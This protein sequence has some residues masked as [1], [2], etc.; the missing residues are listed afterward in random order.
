MSAALAIEHG[1]DAPVDPESAERARL[2]AF[3]RDVRALEDELRA[4]MG[5]DDVAH[6]ERLCA[7][8]DKGLRWGR[9]LTAVGFD[10]ITFGLG[11]ALLSVS[12]LL[13]V[14]PLGHDIYHGAWDKVPGAERFASETWDWDAPIDKEI[15]LT[16]HNRRHH[17]HTGKAE[18]DAD[19]H[20][21]FARINPHVRRDALTRWQLMVA[22][23]SLGAFT[24]LAHMQY[25]GVFDAFA[26]KVLGRPRVHAE[27]LTTRQAL[28]R[29][30]RSVRGYVKRH[31]LVGPLW[32][33]PLAPK[34]WLGEWIAGRVRDLALFYFGFA[35]HAGEGSRWHPEEHRSGSRGAWLRDQVAVTYNTRLPYWMST[36]LDAVDFHIEHHV[37]HRLPSHLYRVAAPRLEAIC[38]EH[39]V[40]YRVEPLGRRIWATFREFWRLR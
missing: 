36:V 9:A 33:G 32:W 30:W 5:S 18:V 35:T 6:L 34:V 8:R 39:G 40:P 27:V 26:D 14:G 2:D 37:F 19:G 20:F 17:P 13:S 29:W 12:K 7:W 10:P 3:A 15:W 11:C 4:G 1:V 28:G 16:M 23:L 21:V 22:V 38:A 25:M 24:H 31:Y